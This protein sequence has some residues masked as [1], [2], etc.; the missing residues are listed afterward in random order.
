[1][2]AT[3]TVS[4]GT[5]AA[6]DAGGVA[7]GGSGTAAMTLTGTV[8]EINTFISGGSVTFTSALNALGDVTLD[9]TIDDGGNSGTGGA[10]TV[11]ASITLEVSETNDAPE[12][13]APVSLTVLE[14]TV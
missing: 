9:V 13:T 4:S 10:L 1:V 11:S 6:A 2:T 7:V 5:L 14:D 3:L 12:V 8:T